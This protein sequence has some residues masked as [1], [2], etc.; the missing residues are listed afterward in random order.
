MQMPPMHEQK[1]KI[2]F[3]AFV[4]FLVNNCFA[5]D[6]YWVGGSGNW[7]DVNNW[8]TT[9]GGTVNYTSLPTSNDDVFFD[10]NSFNAAGQTVNIPATVAN[11]YCRNMNWNGANNPNF[12]SVANVQ[13]NISGSLTLIPTMGFAI[14]GQF[15]FGGALPTKN[16]ISSGKTLPN[17]VFDA[18]STT[19][20]LLDAFS[21][22]A[23]VTL[24]NGNLNFNNQNFNVTNAFN[25]N[26]TNT[27]QLNIA[28]STATVGTWNVNGTN[29]TIS[30]A[31]SLID[32]NNFNHSGSAAIYHNVQTNSLNGGGSTFNWVNSLLNL[33][34][35]GNNIIDSVTVTQDLNQQNNPVIQVLSVGRDASITGNSSI[36][37]FYVGGVLS[38]SGAHTIN[39]TSVDSNAYFFGSNTFDSLIF[40]GID[41]YI[42]IENNATQT[43]TSLLEI[44]GACTASAIM[45]SA[46]QGVQGTWA[47]AGANLTLDYLQLRDINI[48]GTP[49]LNITNLT[50][51]SNVSGLT[52]TNNPLKLF[53]VGGTGNWND[54]NHWSLSSGGPGGSCIPR[55]ID[56][57]MFDAA[58]F[59]AGGQIVWVNVQ[60]ATC[61]TMNWLGA[62]NTPTIQHQ[63]QSQAL[64]VYGSFFLSANMNFMYFG[65]RWLVFEGSAIGQGILSN[66]NTIPCK[67][68]VRGINGQFF[69]MDDFHNADEFELKHGTLDLTSFN[70]TC[71]VFSSNFNYNRGLIM[72][73]DTI[74]TLG[75]GPANWVMNGQ[76]LTLNAA[77]SLIV[78]NNGNFT[79]TNT[80]QSYYDVEFFMNN[81]PPG[82]F[83]GGSSTFNQV[84]A[85]VIPAA[86]NF[87]NFILN[88]NNTIDSVLIYSGFA[89][90]NGNPTIN[91]MWVNG[92]GN[93]T[94]NA[95]I[96]GLE[97]IEQANFT[98]ASGA[99]VGYGRFHHD[100]TFLSSN[101][102]GTL[103]LEPG[104]AYRF[105][106]TGTTTITT[107][108]IASGTC[109]AVIYLESTLAGSQANIHSNM[110]INLTF[111]SVRDINATG[112]TPFNATSSINMGNNTNWSF[113]A[114]T[115]LSLY[116]V[117]G[118][119]NWNDLSHWAFS[120][121]GTPGACI[122]SAL[123]TV[124]FDQNSFLTN[125]D[126]VFVNVSNAVCGTMNWTGSNTSPTLTTTD[127]AN[128]IRIFKSL[129]FNP[130][131]INEFDG[132]FRFEATNPG[133]FVHSYQ[134]PFL[135][136]IYFMGNGGEWTLQDTLVVI[137]NRAVVHTLGSIDVDKK[138]IMANYLSN[139]TGI[140]AM[141][142]DSA[143][144]QGAFWTMNGTN[145]TFSGLH[146][147]IQCN[148]LTHTGNR[149]VYHDAQVTNLNGSTAKLRRVDCNEITS[150]A[151]GYID[152]LFLKSLMPGN[153]SQLNGWDTINFMHSDSICIVNGNQ[154]V[155][156]ANFNGN[157]ILQGNHYFR[158]AHMHDNGRMTG[159]NRIDTLYITAGKTY[160]LGASQTQVFG[161]IRSRWNPCYPIFWRSTLPGTQANM[162]ILFGPV[163]TNFMEIRDINHLNNHPFYAGLLGVN[164]GNNTNILFAPEPNNVF[165]FPTDSLIF[166]CSGSPTDSVVIFGNFWEPDSILWSTGSMA[167]SVVV[168]PPDTIWANV[169]Y[170]NCLFTD[171]LKVDL[172]IFSP[173]IHNTEND[174]T[175][176]ENDSLVLTANNGHPGL[177]YLWS[178]GDTTP[179]ITVFPTQTTTYSVTVSH[180]A[181]SCTDDI[182]ISVLPMPPIP[183]L[184]D[185]INCP[186]DTAF[187]DAGPNYAQYLWSNGDTTQIA[188]Y[189]QD[190]L[191]SV[192]VYNS[193][194]CF[195]VIPFE[196][197]A[198]N[199]I[200]Y[201][202]IAIP[203]SCNGFTDGGVYIDTTTLDTAYA[204]QWNG[205][206][207]M[208]PKMSNLAPGYYRIT[209]YGSGICFKI[210]SILVAE[211]PLP[212]FRDSISMP[213]CVGDSNGSVRLFPV[214]NN[215]NMQFVWNGTDT[216]NTQ[217][218]LPSAW[219]SFLIIDTNLCVYPDSVFIPQPD[220]VHISTLNDTLICYND[221]I[222]VSATASH[223]N[224]SP[225]SFNWFGIAGDGPHRILPL[226]DTLIRVQTS[227]SK[228][229]LSDTAEF[230]IQLRQSI[231]LSVNT[232]VELC[233]GNEISIQLRVQGDSTGIAPLRFIWS[234]GDT[235]SYTRT[236]I[237]IEDEYNISVVGAC[238]QNGADTL[239][240]IFIQSPLA[241]FDYS[242]SYRCDGIE[243]QIRNLSENA[244]RYEWTLPNGSKSNEENPELAWDFNGKANIELKA[245][246]DNCFSVYK[247]TL[248]NETLENAIRLAL[249]NVISPNGDGV[250]DV[251]RLNDR[252]QLTDCMQYQIYNRWGN[253][254]F[255]G[256]GEWDGHTY[257]GQKVPDGTYFFTVSVLD[258][259]FQGSVM[260][261]GD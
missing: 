153:A 231:T 245:I 176:C 22:N 140:R 122:P 14:I 237:P 171:T 253:L 120:S 230:R 18:P 34:T 72:V 81:A 124:Y 93:F 216:S 117:G 56:T 30:A 115:P 178:T 233:T 98:A 132:V 128:V 191:H 204:Y 71:K 77:Q 172:V 218:N 251:F 66:Q 139:G 38:C 232:P 82:E 48:A 240:L 65:D 127:T 261:M 157:A 144:M 137:N 119:G 258:L 247:T 35:T 99:N 181:V 125:N 57:V 239:R 156:Y 134:K 174:T 103:H 244:K 4:V 189:T 254:I 118:T 188:I 252:F 220:S 70:L 163:S 158:E 51:I 224:G 212:N 20:V 79:H 85:T 54:P 165:G 214:P 96:Q 123:D 75:P 223:G 199:P 55:A 68:S 186:G 94:N 182:E 52:I 136:D 59:T 129:Y 141:Q 173:I 49:T 161:T 86:S 92:K 36:Q 8:A 107:A 1:L 166:K 41:I 229:C 31:A 89:L 113:T 257:S 43:V 109:G 201:D 104:F 234:D 198:I 256:F 64:R 131:V 205:L 21:S 226:Q 10:V 148:T 88:D 42:L 150:G 145:M 126:T 197:V 241:K 213:N 80:P 177:T 210:D 87:P 208:Q 217:N 9:S 90:L 202:L 32:C 6:Y 11:I 16:I 40:N 67:V 193:N 26:N 46:E 222:A 236:F 17:C 116:W 133:H 187:I 29:A 2:L 151:G 105:G 164:Q 100:A 83:F 91:G 114:P 235:S 159:A 246:N 259:R 73:D 69:L 249:P 142:F 58:S 74:T 13:V 121:G 143:F 63:S 95:I 62:S 255:E 78:I 155:F 260:V 15:N 190:G 147:F 211:P 3:L 242:Y 215:L 61:A 47:L 185:T 37:Y 110:A 162:N 200:P 243:S 184:G 135:K 23:N 207:P 108:W 225:Y 39:Y 194:G 248:S 221:S 7:N 219:I 160:Q 5:V 180:Y 203:A 195:N 238:D 33:A 102:F 19:W 60:H 111:C 138:A 130:T 146:S 183:F 84:R 170:G 28:N 167:D 27:R 179:S 12:T 152:S 228:G 192:T 50:E 154:R 97:V 149:S 175:I 209:V 169:W 76:N 250:N 44:N 24:T 112:T 53:W 227:D 106:T 168:F 25:S 45:E 101:T 196:I 206:N